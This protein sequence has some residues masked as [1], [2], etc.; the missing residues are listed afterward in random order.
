MPSWKTP[1]PEQIEH[2]ISLLARPEQ[3][4]YFFDKLQNPE[5]L[6][7]LNQR[8]F[9]STPPA[10]IYD[11]TKGTVQFP[12]WPALQY[13]ARMATIPEAQ[14]AV[15]RIVLNIPETENIIVHGALAEIATKLPAP[16]AAQFVPRVAQWLKVSYPYYGVLPMHL[17]TLLKHLAT[18]GQTDAAT[19]L[20]RVTL[21]ITKDEDAQAQYIVGVMYDNA[22][23]VSQDNKEAIKWY[24][25]AA[26]QGYAPAQSDLGVAYAQGHG[27]PKNDVEAVNWYRKAADHGLADAQS[28]LGQMYYLGH[29]IPKNDVEA[30][31]WFRKAADH[32]FAA[33]QANLGVMYRDGQGVPKNDVEAVNWFRKAA[34]QGFADAQSKLGQMYHEG[35]G[36]PHNDVEAINWFRKAADQGLALAQFNLAVMYRDG[37]GVPK[38]DVEALS[39]LRKAADQ[40]SAQA[41][42]SLGDAGNSWADIPVWKEASGA[43]LV[44]SASRCKRALLGYGVPIRQEFRTDQTGL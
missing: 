41:Q 40:G 23:G 8:G 3:R 15:L 14:D 11:N 1:T 19:A 5:W 20:A 42:S 32:G 37:Q 4:R 44:N 38:N 31:N 30:V 43:I 17:G 16:M 18:N 34:D 6:E 36:V 9:F 28:N 27:V 2:A 35:Q 7:P 13:L 29:G 12:P 39:W 26:D 25:L 21:A 10:P 33:A 22:F 24:R